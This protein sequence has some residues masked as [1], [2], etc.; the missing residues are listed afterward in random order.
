[1][2]YHLL[3]FGLR[4]IIIVII[5]III[6]PWYFIPKGIRNCEGWKNHELGVSRL[7]ASYYHI[8]IAEWISEAHTQHWNGGKGKHFSGGSLVNDEM[9]RP[10]AAMSSLADLRWDIISSVIIDFLNI[11]MQTNHSDRT[12]AIF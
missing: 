11:S 2:S 5:I 9:R 6:R 3:L 12:S 8:D 1:M 4:I 7:A 10:R